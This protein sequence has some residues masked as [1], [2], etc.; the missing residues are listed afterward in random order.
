MA[1]RRTRAT[2]QTGGGGQRWLWRRSSW[3]YLPVG[4]QEGYARLP[5]VAV[6]RIET[7][8]LTIARGGRIVL[9]GIDLAGRRRRGDR[10]GRASGA[11]KSS[12]LR[13][14]VRLDQPAGGRGAGGRAR[15]ARARPVRAAAS[16]R[17][18]GAGAGDARGRRAGEPRLRARRADD[19]RA[20]RRARR[21]RPRPV[22][23]GPRP[24]A[25]CPAARRR[26]WRSR[27]RWRATRARCCSTSRPRRSTRGRGADRGRSCAPRRRGLGGPRRHAR[28][29]A[30]RAV[31][32]T[33][34]SR[35]A[36]DAGRRRRRARGARDR[37]LARGPGS[38]L[39]RDLAISAVRAG[40]QL[41]AVGAI[42]TLVFEHGGLAAGFVA[43][44]L[45][46]ATFTSAAGWA[47][48]RTRRCAPAPRSP[49]AR[50]RASC[51]CSSAARS[52]PRRAS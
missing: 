49:R 42:V 45:G 8:D 6:P 9:R 2:P 39:E 43:V 17:A 44:M 30:G 1:R 52:A 48:S 5:A 7:Q 24:R 12:L 25:S 37:A 47:G 11:G 26:G 27:G 33:R 38:R 18:R 29:G 19:R 16:G 46:T 51:R 50:R 32:P 13:C 31:S 22:V 23:H 41:A 20:R 10:A 14:L 15:R 28:R 21:D 40:V 35:S 34:G 4:Q 3:A 36:R